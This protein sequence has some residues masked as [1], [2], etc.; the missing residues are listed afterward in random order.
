MYIHNPSCSVAKRVGSVMENTSKSIWSICKY[1]SNKVFKI[2]YNDV[3]SV[4][5]R[6]VI[7]I[8]NTKCTLSSVYIHFAQY[9][10]LP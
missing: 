2:Q 1:F 6:L 7:K 5:P 10:D 4:L 8:Q 9:D 3:K